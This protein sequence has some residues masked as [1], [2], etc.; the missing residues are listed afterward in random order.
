MKNKPFLCAVEPDIW[1]LA[2]STVDFSDISHSSSLEETL[3]FELIK[4]CQLKQPNIDLFFF[5]KLLLKL[6]SV[7]LQF[8][9]FQ[10][11]MTLV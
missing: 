1:M 8:K 3:A 4:T 7:S 2:A 6:T 11:R 9:H 10:K 5:F